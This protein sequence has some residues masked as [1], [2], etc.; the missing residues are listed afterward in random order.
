MT[1]L[2]LIYN[3]RRLVMFKTGGVQLTQKFFVKKKKNIQI[4]I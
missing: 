1:I 2:K 3:R 4:Q